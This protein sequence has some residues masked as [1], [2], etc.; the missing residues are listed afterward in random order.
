ML[1]RQVNSLLPSISP[2][3]SFKV[4]GMIAGRLLAKQSSTIKR[5]PEVPRVA[6][7]FRSMR[8]VCAGNVPDGVKPLWE[9]ATACEGNF[10]KTEGGRP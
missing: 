9:V 2:I 6:S 4:D 8:S 3:E 7:E 10:W 5:F 1:D